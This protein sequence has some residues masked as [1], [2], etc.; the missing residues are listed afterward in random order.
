MS[1]IDAYAWRKAS[2]STSNNACVEVAPLTEVTGIRDTKDRAQGH[3]EIS[4]AAWRELL[5]ALRD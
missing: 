5:R 1:T 3:L 2:R 4:S